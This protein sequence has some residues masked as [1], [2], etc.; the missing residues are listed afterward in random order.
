MYMRGSHP[1]CSGAG[2][3][4]LRVACLNMSVSGFTQ[5]SRFVFCPQHLSRSKKLEAHYFTLIA[6]SIDY[7]AKINAQRDQD[8]VLFFSRLSYSQFPYQGTT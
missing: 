8:S 2:I 5:N 3:S 4:G 1:T 6:T 7:A